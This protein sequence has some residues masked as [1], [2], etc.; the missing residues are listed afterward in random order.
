MFSRKAEQTLDPS[1]AILESPWKAVWSS[2]HVLTPEN[3]QIYA[4]IVL[5]LNPT[6][7]LC[8]R[9][10]YWNIFTSG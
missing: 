8:L 5:G 3:T 9:P 4:V 2:A 10:V 7:A 1:I 6:S